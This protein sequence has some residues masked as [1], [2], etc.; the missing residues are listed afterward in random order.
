VLSNW[1][2]HHRAQKTASASARCMKAEERIEESSLVSLLRR[3]CQ[4][5][6]KRMA[7]SSRRLT[8]LGSVSGSLIVLASVNDNAKGPSTPRLSSRFGSATALGRGRKRGEKER[9]ST[10]PLQLMT[11]ASLVLVFLLTSCACCPS[12]TFLPV[13]A[14]EEKRPPRSREV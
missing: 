12:N 3:L 7:H 13:T 10:Y 4:S 1:L 8:P 14:R 5:G 11:S 6:H 9:G 2:F